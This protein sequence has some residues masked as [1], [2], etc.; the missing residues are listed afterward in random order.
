[1]KAYA[2]I[3]W[4]LRVRG[5]RE[6]GYHLLETLMQTITLHDTLSIKPARSWS[7]RCNVRALSTRDNLMMKAARLLQKA[8]G[9]RGCYHMYLRKSIPSGAGLG[10]GSADAAAVLRFLK[11]KWQVGEETLF[12]CAAELG[13]DV[14]FLLRGGS[15]LCTGIGE[16]MENTPLP[17][18][19]L[20]L[21]KPC[22]G[23]A[24]REV[25]S[26]YDALPREEGGHSEEESAQ[27]IAAIRQGDWEFL[28]RENRNDLLGAALARRKPIGAALEALKDA[29]A[30]YRQMSGSG[31][32]VYGVFPTARERDTAYAA[33][34][35]RYKSLWKAETIISS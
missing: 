27:V 21:I 19:P 20:L 28:S 15:A 31:S 2:K 17:T 29:G 10:G 6:D 9:E 22:A 8:T 35:G 16:R 33:L 5:Q 3:N 13:A 12:R 30:A 7:L 24:T 14:P 25:F 4:M 32:C 1:M 26:L 34:S 11:T 23:L 18:W